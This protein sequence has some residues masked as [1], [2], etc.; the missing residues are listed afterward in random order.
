[1]EEIKKLI[2]EFNGLRRSVPAWATSSLKDGTYSYKEYKKKVREIDKLEK[3]VKE[4]LIK[5]GA[6]GDSVL[7]MIHS[8]NDNELH[9]AY[10]K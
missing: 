3:K 4:A 7:S 10:L 8:L 9:C 1:M 2:I 6:K 5:F